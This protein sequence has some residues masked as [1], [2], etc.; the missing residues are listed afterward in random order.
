MR[1]EWR[2][3]SL[4]KAERMR[5]IENG[6]DVN[7]DSAVNGDGELIRAAQVMIDYHIH[8]RAN[9]VLA[10]SAWPWKEPEESF[11]RLCLKINSDDPKGT[12]RPLQIAGA[13]IAAEIDRLQANSR[14]EIVVERRLYYL[15]DDVRSADWT[16]QYSVLVNG[17]KVMEFED[18]WFYK[19]Y[20]GLV[21]VRHKALTA[22]GQLA[23][24][25]GVATVWTVEI[26]TESVEQEVSEQSDFRLPHDPRNAENAENA[27]TPERDG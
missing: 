21:R 4:I 12:V 6:R 3:V 7:H 26:S 14:P 5:Q 15:D 10:K 2:G 27:E 17:T 9:F 22:A 20:D 18:G 25:L 19:D 23:E 24:A 11:K 1:K 13:L 8:G 16:F